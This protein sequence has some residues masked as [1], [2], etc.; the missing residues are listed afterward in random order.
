MA[1]NLEISGLSAET[2]YSNLQ[3]AGVTPSDAAVIVSGWIYEA[4]GK[5]KRTFDYQQTFP[6]TTPGCAAAFNRTFVHQD[7]IDGE[8]LVQAQQS[9]GEDGFNVR[10]HR[11]ETDLDAIR[12]DMV[13]AYTC[14]AEMRASL[15]HLLDE[16]RAELNRLNNDVYTLR[17]EPDTTGPGT[18]GPIVKNPKFLGVTK[19]ANQSVSL[20]NT[21]QGMFVLPVP[22]TFGVDPV[23][24][25]RVRMTS[26]LSRYLQETPAVQQAFP[27]GF[28][29]SDLIERFGNERTRDG[30]TVGELVTIL[31]DSVRYQN[32]PAMLEDIAD[33]QAAALRTTAGANQA[34]MD[35]FG[36]ETGVQSVEAAPIETLRTVPADARAG[37]SRAGI[38]SVGKLAGAQPQ[39]IARA[40]Q[41]SGLTGYSAGDVAEWA[42]AAKVLTRVR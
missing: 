17:N 42:G 22:Q 27:E 29:K 16:I 41:E 9:A 36:L 2:V 25:Q 26:E 28:T 30:S 15:R 35:A 20:W 40:L 10:F 7:W 31:P 21:D 3:K 34:V 18:I 12:A 4:L 23:N 8:S 14:L 24:D 19:L 37:L 1:G 5:G 11:I 33:R 39:E 13:L 6:E 38:T 32:V